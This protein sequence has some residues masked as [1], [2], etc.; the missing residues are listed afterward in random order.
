VQ[1]FDESLSAV[2]LSAQRLAIRRGQQ[3]CEPQHVLWAVLA[4]DQG[5]AAMDLRREG[6]DVTRILQRVEA[7]LPPPART[8]GDPRGMAAHDGV[9]RVSPALKRL[10]DS[11][12]VLATGEGSGGLDADQA[13]I[14]A[15]AASQDPELA[16]LVRRVGI[17]SDVTSAG[18]DDSQAG[19]GAL[20]LIGQYG[21][22]LTADARAGRLDPLIG[23]EAELHRVMNILGRRRKNNPVLIGEPGVGK[24][25]IVEGLAQAIAAG[26]VPDALKGRHV[27]SLDVGSLVAGTKYRGEFEERVQVLLDGIARAKGQ[28]ILFIDE[29]HMIARAGGAEGAIDAAS[30]FKPL[31][32][33]GELNAIG[34]TTID[35]YR[36]HIAKDGALERRFQPVFVRE[37]SEAE[38]IE[39]L[40]GLRSTYERHHAVTITDEALVTAVQVSVRALPERRLPDKAIDLI[41][42]AS[43]ECRR[44]VDGLSSREVPGPPEPDRGGSTVSADDVRR[45][46]D[47][48]KGQG[49][50]DAWAERVYASRSPGLMA[51]IRRA[52]R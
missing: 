2:L 47:E 15:L 6:R 21:R 52:I 1:S 36:Q 48:W 24:T 39:I 14:A 7:E 40:R 50:M 22:D 46:V 25:A 19:L 33:R 10:I 20:R 27:F 5:S 8:F 4:D 51:R 31:L 18:G 32:A 13:I 29:L 38:A 28:I 3:A 9:M 16:G 11:A 35:E 49:G 26:T 37:P 12:E 44:R 45:T 41:D 42:E 30:F 23:R 43:S 34:A 17:V